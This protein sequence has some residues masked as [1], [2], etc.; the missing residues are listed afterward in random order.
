MVEVRPF[1]EADAEAVFQMRVRTFSSSA[2]GTWD[3]DEVYIPDDRRIVAVDRGQVVGH[4][5]VWSFAQAYGG[6]AVPMGG[7]G[8]VIVEPTA[9]G[10]GLA[11]AMLA[12]GVEL[13]REHGDAIST[14]Y[15]ATVTPY[16]RAGWEIAGRR[17]WRRLPTRSLLDLPRPVD[18]PVLRTFVADDLAEAVALQ[19]TAALEEAGGLCHAERW[20][21]RHLMPDDDEPEA[22][23]VAE[24]HGRMVGLVQ[25][26][27]VAAT[28]PHS[29]HDL[30]VPRFVASDHDTAMALWRHVGTGWS[31]AR[32]ARIVVAPGEPLLLDLPEAD[33]DHDR[34]PDV[35]MSRLVD[36]PGAVAARGYHPGARI[37]VPLHVEDPL[38]PA[39]SGDVVLEVQDGVGAATPGGSGRV[40][41]DVGTLAPLFT[42]HLSAAA[43]ARAGRLDGATDADVTALRAAFDGPAPFLRDYF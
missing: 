24:R 17:I 9:R 11:T 37:S 29:S 2:S 22:V 40:R 21:R 10:R 23:T 20:L 19:D 6:R 18:P 34:A 13:M 36:I 31:V 4:L 43:L 30:V 15:P 27:R 38:V 25:T 14:L 39:N 35:W 12:A 3:P 33:L 5:G 16:R 32:L 42:G 41:V 28:A 1:D 8:A 26:I 7:V